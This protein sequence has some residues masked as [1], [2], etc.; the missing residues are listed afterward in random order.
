MALGRSREFSVARA[1]TQDASGQ[2]C[3]KK[4]QQSGVHLGTHK[5]LWQG[6]KNLDLLETGAGTRGRQA[7]HP[8][9]K[10]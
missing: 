10:I 2:S 3:S 5:N 6:F 7:R 4:K 1:R 8:E 9:H